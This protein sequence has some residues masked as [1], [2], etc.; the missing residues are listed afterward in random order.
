[1]SEWNYNLEEA[2]KDTELM[3]SVKTRAWTSELLGRFDD[4]KFAKKPR[5]YWK[6]YLWGVTFSRDN[7]PYA[8][9]LPDPAPLPE[10]D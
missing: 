1:M 4:D 6:Y 9:R 2:P 10:G 7:P 8:W 3:F 5:P